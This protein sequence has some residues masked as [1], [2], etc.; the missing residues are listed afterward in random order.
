MILF[1]VYSPSLRFFFACSNTFSICFFFSLAV[2]VCKAS[3]LRSRFQQLLQVEYLFHCYFCIICPCTLSLRFYAFA[4]FL[5]SDHTWCVH[6]MGFILSSCFIWDYFSIH[7]SIVLL[8]STVVSKVFM[9]CGFFF[10]FKFLFNLVILS[11]DIWSLHMIV[12]MY[13]SSSLVIYWL[14]QSSL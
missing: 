4:I 14:F 11:S 10:F 12:F 9:L 3:F 8:S 2:I 7:F 5:S 1:L 6:I 13:L